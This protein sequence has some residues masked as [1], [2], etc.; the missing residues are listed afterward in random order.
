MEPEIQ[1]A[2][3]AS[4]SEGQGAHPG[5][6]PLIP[7][8]GAWNMQLVLSSSLWLRFLL[9]LKAFSG[10]F[11][12]ELAP[13]AFWT[14]LQCPL[15]RFL[16]GEEPQL[17]SGV[18]EKSLLRPVLNLEHW[19]V[20]KGPPEAYF[21]PS[22]YWFHFVV[23]NSC[24]PIDHSESFPPPCLCVSFHLLC[25]SVPIFCFPSWKVLIC[26]LASHV[27][28]VSYLWWLLLLSPGHLSFPLCFCPNR[29]PRLCPAL[30]MLG[31]HEFMQ[32]QKAPK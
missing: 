15:C 2:V 17:G 1:G 5:M 18:C 3:S 20:W 14:H 6:P 26:L 22:N 13:A 30:E 19:D 29:G 16:Q 32:W 8:P 31:S 7:V 11:F 25:L 4:A 27:G 21:E 10:L 28:A 24:I 12:C 23:P 9:N